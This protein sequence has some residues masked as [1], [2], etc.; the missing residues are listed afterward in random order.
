[1]LILILHHTNSEHGFMYSNFYNSF[2]PSINAST[3]VFPSL[4][5]N[6]ITARKLRT[7][8]HT[9]TGRRGI[10]ADTE[11][12]SQAATEPEFIRST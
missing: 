5:I 11:T 2:S 9:K 1:M 10:F 8:L 7:T 12:D 4:I 3:A 6:V